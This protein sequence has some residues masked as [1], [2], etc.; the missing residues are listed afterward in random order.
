MLTNSNYN[1][2][3]SRSKIAICIANMNKN[4]IPI[5]KSC[6]QISPESTSQNYTG[7]ACYSRTN[8]KV[9]NRTE[10]Q[11]GLK[12]VLTEIRIAERNTRTHRHTLTC[13][14][15]DMDHHTVFT[16]MIHKQAYTQPT[17]TNAINAH[18]KAIRK[19]NKNIGVE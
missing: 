8:G 5:W 9:E 14:C 15:P 12:P 6:K 7:N 11:F 2:V 17:H 18:T 3:N 13:T 10:T 4:K 16:R 1:G 19:H